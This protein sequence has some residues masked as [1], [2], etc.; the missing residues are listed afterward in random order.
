MNVYDGGG[1]GSR[2][3]RVCAAIHSLYA[4]LIT[5]MAA[6][7]LSLAWAAGRAASVNVR[8]GA[9]DYYVG[10]EILGC[11]AVCYIVCAVGL[12]RPARWAWWLSL[13]INVVGIAVIVSDVVSGDRDPDNWTAIAAL[14]VPAASL[15][16]PG[17]RPVR[18]SEQAYE[19]PVS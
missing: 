18:R 13:V 10:S 14:L 9:H 8:A 7:T 19:Q 3:S 15:F 5:G 2:G 1:R 6:Y 12:W 4:L 11:A 17:A 16:L